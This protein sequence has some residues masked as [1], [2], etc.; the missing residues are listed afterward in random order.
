MIHATCI[1][2]DEFRKW[3]WPDHFLALPQQGDVVRS[4]EDSKG[5][6][7]LRVAKIVH[8]G[9]HDDFTTYTQVELHL[10]PIVLTG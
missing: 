6:A 7:E 2:P 1:V 10:A 3:A 5:Y 9:L 4:V 8:V